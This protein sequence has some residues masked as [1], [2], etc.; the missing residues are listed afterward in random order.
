MICL[1]I[2]VEGQGEWEINEEMIGYA[3]VVGHLEA[4][5]GGFP[6]DWWSRVAHPAFAANEAILYR[7]G[8]DAGF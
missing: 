4:A 7:R 5:V 2:D 1:L 8:A 3:D 6:A